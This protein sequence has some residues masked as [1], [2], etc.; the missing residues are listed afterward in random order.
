MEHTHPAKDRPRAEAPE[1]RLPFT[2]RKGTGWRPH[3]NHPLT[4]PTHTRT[5]AH[6]HACMHTSPVLTHICRSTHVH[7]LTQDECIHIHTCTP[8]QTCLCSHAHT[9]TYTTCA[10]I[11][12]VHTQACTCTLTSHIQIM[13]TATCI[14]THPQACN[15]A[16]THVHILKPNQVSVGHPFPLPAKT[17]SWPR[18]TAFRLP[19]PGP[20]RSPSMS[21]PTVLPPQ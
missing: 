19:N 2:L 13:H 11:T 3:P 20:R 15:H 8:M 17:T 21:V 16:C 1:P 9:C 18:R 4:M 7:M 12:H 10:D 6:G 5:N 14:H